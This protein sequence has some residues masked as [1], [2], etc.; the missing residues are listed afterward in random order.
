MTPAGDPVPPTGSPAPAR[1]GP[2]GRAP[3]RV[4]VPVLVLVA[5]VVA[6]TSSVGAPLIP[7][8]ADLYDVPLHVAQW[9]LTMPLLVGAVATPVLGRLG[10][11]S[12]RRAVALT[13]LTLVVLGGVLTALPLTLGWFLAGRG[14]QGF[15]LG[16]MPLLIATAREALPP[17]RSRRT[18]AA[19]S[20]TVVSGV[21]LGYPIAGAITTYAGATAAF[22]TATAVCAGALAAAALVLPPASAAPPRRFDLP[23]ALL[24]GAGLAGALVTLSEGEGWGWTSGRVLLLGSAALVLLA[25]WAALALRTRAPLIDLRLARGRLPASG[26]ASV[27]LVSLANYLMLGSVPILAQTPAD[28][29][30]GFGASGLVAGLLLLPFSLAGMLAGPLSRRLGERVRPRVVLVVGAL[31]MAAAQ[32]LFAAYRS[33]LWVLLV[34]TAVAGLGVSTVFAAA[35]GLVV[36]AVPPRETGSAMALNQVLRY[37]GFA[38]GSASTATVLAVATPA[39]GELPAGVAYT[40]I[41]VI[42]SATCVLA[43]LVVWF[44]AGRSPAQPPSVAPRASGDTVRA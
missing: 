20:I 28:S 35:A 40:V 8:V 23:G 2:T 22:W 26:H 5:T 19:L 15:G 6:V 10:D 29:G 13:A 25:A 9:S 12:H 24:L 14:L 36:S 33:E 30:Y 21:G 7:A 42:G 1:P 3:S 43:A 34:V 31:L 4:L 17:D 39:G 27:L 11:G 37:A 38:V 16:L 44:L 32:G 41:G 18:I